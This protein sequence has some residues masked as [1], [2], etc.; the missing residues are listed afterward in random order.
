[1]LRAIVPSDASQSLIPG[2]AAPTARGI[3]GSHLVR[4]VHVFL[5]STADAPQW[6]RLVHLELRDI[7]AAWAV[8][9]PCSDCG[10]RHRELFRLPRG[11]GG[12]EGGFEHALAVV[13]KWEAVVRRLAPD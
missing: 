11:A 4:R 8:Q 10:A 9:P 1:V 13:R 5:C 12:R 3:V 2:A 7:N 6:E